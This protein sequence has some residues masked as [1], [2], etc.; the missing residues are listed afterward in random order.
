MGHP[1]EAI[2]WL[3]NLLGTYS[4]RLNAG[5]IIMTGSVTPVMWLDSVPCHAEIEFDGLG[6]ASL[7][8]T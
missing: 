2:A 6:I 3:A 7:E 4:E 5:D 8:L 1:L